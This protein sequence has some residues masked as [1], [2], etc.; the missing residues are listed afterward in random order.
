MLLVNH[1]EE[2][3]DKS[4]LILLLHV[5]CGILRTRVLELSV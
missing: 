2:D 5:S 3:S 1:S 4:C